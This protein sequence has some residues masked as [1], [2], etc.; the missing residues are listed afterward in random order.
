MSDNF[1]VKPTFSI[2]ETTKIG[3]TIW[4]KLLK[5]SNIYIPVVVIYRRPI[6][7][8]VVLCSNSAGRNFVNLAESSSAVF[9]LPDFYFLILT[10]SRVSLNGRTLRAELEPEARLN[11]V[12]ICRVKGETGLRLT[13]VSAGCVLRVTHVRVGYSK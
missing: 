12:G 8:V 13:R 1:C 6:V 4:T 10:L 5:N 3:A 9:S 2:V 11:A 7:P